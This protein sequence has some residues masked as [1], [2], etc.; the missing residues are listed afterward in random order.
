PALQYCQQQGG[1]GR[2]FSAST[3]SMVSYGNGPRILTPRQRLSV[4]INERTHFAEVA[5]AAVSIVKTIPPTCGSDSGKASSPIIPCIIWDFVARG[6]CEAGKTKLCSAGGNQW[7]EPMRLEN[8]LLQLDF[9]SYEND[10]KD[11]ACEELQAHPLRSRFL[12]GPE[13]P[14]SCG[15]FSPH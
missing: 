8:I 5:L 9:T 10:Q 14:C 12:E 1:T 6:I 3:T 4:E 11:R 7:L 2:I 13:N 15:F